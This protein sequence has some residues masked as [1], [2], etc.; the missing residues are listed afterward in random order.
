MGIR[1]KHTQKTAGYVVREC[2]ARYRAVTHR[3]QHHSASHT[4]LDGKTTASAQFEAFGLHPTTD[5]RCYPEAFVMLQEYAFGPSVARFLESMH[6]YVKHAGK[7]RS[8]LG[9]PASVSAKTRAPQLLRMLNCPKAM[10]I[11]YLYQRFVHIG[12]API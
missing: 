5:L 6:V 3:C 8:K 2:F 7:S 12:A 1:F 10:Y 4:L 9:K 11:L